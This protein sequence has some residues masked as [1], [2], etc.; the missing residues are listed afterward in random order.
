MN[1]RIPN[2]S[3]PY[4]VEFIRRIQEYGVDLKAPPLTETRDI[5]ANRGGRAEQREEGY[6]DR[7]KQVL[8]EKMGFATDGGKHARAD[9]IV[10][11]NYGKGSQKA[12]HDFA[13]AFTEGKLKGIPGDVLAQ[14]RAAFADSIKEAREAHAHHDHSPA[15]SPATSVPTQGNQR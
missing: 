13:V 7:E 9:G 4:S 14:A 6:T 10:D 12:E 5:A 8:L 15:A 11:G 1:D 2:P 3:T